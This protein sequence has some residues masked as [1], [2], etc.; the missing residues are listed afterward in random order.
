MARNFHETF[1]EGEVVS[2]RVLPTL[3]VITI[4]RKILHNEIVYTTQS[5]SFLR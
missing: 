2:D 4:V 5:E 1:V 3:L